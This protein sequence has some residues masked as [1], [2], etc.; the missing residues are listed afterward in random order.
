MYI[1]STVSCFPQWSF[2]FWIFE[3]WIKLETFFRNNDMIFGTHSSAN[4]RHQKNVTFWFAHDKYDRH[5]CKMYGH[6]RSN[7][8]FTMY[9]AGSNYCGLHNIVKGRNHQNIF[10]H[11]VKF[12]NNYFI[13]ESNFVN[14]NRVQIG[15]KLAP[16]RVSKGAQFLNSSGVDSEIA[17]GNFRGTK[18]YKNEAL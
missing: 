2:R 9:D 14:S 13:D 8:L 6:S 7:N 3:R 16:A 17:L 15:K 4:F 18:I 11:A 12:T 5:A 10:N 1:T